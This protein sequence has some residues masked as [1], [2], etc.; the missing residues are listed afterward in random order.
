ML[1]FQFYERVKVLYGNGAINQAGELAKSL[2]KNKALIVCD[3]GILK[4]DIVD[5][6]KAGLDNENIP[7]AVYDKNEPN[8][9]IRACEEA[10][11]MLVAENC[12]FIIGVGGGSNMD[13]AKGVQILKYNP[14]PLM[15]YANGQK[16]FDCG[17]AL[18][19]VPTTSGT[20]SEMS[21]GS[22]LSDE[23]HIKHNFLSDGAIADYCILDPDLMVGMPPKLTAFTGLDAFTHAAESHMGI[24][25]TEF[26]AF[27]SEK[28]IDQ[29]VEYLPR[30]VANGNDM[31]A[32][33][34]MAVAASVGG[35]MLVYGLACAGHSIGQTIGGYF[36]IPH[37]ASVAY[38]MPWVLEFNAPAVPDRVKRIGVSLGVEFTGNE[39]PEE[40]GAL[41]RDAF[42]DFRDNKC[43][44]PSIKTFK[45]DESK[46]DEIAQ[47]C[48]D[49]YFQQIQPRKMTKDDCL[50]ILKKMYA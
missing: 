4:T 34:K 39:T 17:E 15:Q 35:Y 24:L 9:P 14:A 7:Y 37:G 5:K 41:T 2:G 38:A 18:I 47:V 45:Y 48:A 49:E 8:P 11:E 12:D 44:C 10:Y 42:I 6:I 3:A 30:A 13:C 43:K 19:M 16:P 21:N 22:I 33:G 31:E 40:I 46:F 1:N 36:D 29:I 28:V 32:R 26:L 25:S 50:D 27:M 20:G 23:N